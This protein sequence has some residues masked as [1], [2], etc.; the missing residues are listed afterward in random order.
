MIAHLNGRPAGDLAALAFAGFAHFTAAQVRDR[1]VRA[2]D[3]HLE[4]LDAASLELFGRAEPRVRE[5]L[6]TALEASPADVSV[7]VAVHSAEFVG[8]G[9]LNV[10]V[11][12][13]E[14]ANGPTG[15]L[16]LDVVRHERWMPHIKH[17]GEAAKTYLLRAA[18]ARGFDD[19]AFTDATGRLSEATIWNLAF[20]DGEN[21]LWP[22]A[23]YLTG[24]TMGIL[25]RRLPVPQKT[26]DLRPE[27]LA[28]L[29]GVVMNSWTPAVPL[30]RVG[31][32]ELADAGEFTG[33]LREAFDREEWTEV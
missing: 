3:L 29:A 1:R 25:R 23:E 24:T 2:L 12:T 22:R 32:V 7:T 5:Y 14:P 31:D 16:A 11:R 30:S 4:R 18:K 33:L 13:S 27:D 21:V 8:D 26:V 10:L 9:P 19:A 17:T 28:G 15:P 20:W 6:R